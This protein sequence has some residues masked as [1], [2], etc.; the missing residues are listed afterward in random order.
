[1]LY[2]LTFSNVQSYSLKLNVNDSFS[3][4]NLSISSLMLS[5]YVPVSLIIKNGLCVK[6]PSYHLHVLSISFNF[7]NIGFRDDR[8]ANINSPWI[9]ESPFRF[10][11]YK[12]RFLLEGRQWNCHS[13]FPIELPAGICYLVLTITFPVNWLLQWIRRC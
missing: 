7:M 5:W 10:L 3:V 1:M 2:V 8:V 12:Y 11:T 4:G 9:R 13:K 6:Y